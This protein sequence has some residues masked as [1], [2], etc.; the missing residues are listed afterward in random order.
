VLPRGAAYPIPTPR[1]ERFERFLGKVHILLRHGLPPL[2]REAFGGSTSLVDAEID[3]NPCDLALTRENDPPSLL[4]DVTAAVC[5]AT[6]FADSRE[7]HAVAE[8]EHLLHI[9]MQIGPYPEP[10]LDPAS[11]RGHALEG[12]QPLVREVPDRIGSME[13]HDRVNVMAIP[14][15]KRLSHKL[16]RVGG[17]GLL[18]HGREYPGGDGATPSRSAPFYP[19][20]TWA[21]TDAPP[22]HPAIHTLHG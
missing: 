15:V 3:R 13:A 16:D 12:P 21:Y 10:I 11:D 22:A 20:R 19:E 8:V 9:Q 14:G 7:H 2:L 6:V 1:T 5:Q 18:R 17:R 4:L